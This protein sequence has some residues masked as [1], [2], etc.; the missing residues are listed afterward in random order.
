MEWRKG[1]QCAPGIPYA[2][3]ADVCSGYLAGTCGGQHYRFGSVHVSS[4]YY[5]I[6]LRGAYCADAQKKKLESGG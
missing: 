4:Y 6:Y 5:T 2:W 3:V 1:Q